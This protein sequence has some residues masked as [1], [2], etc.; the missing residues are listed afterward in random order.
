MVF[1]GIKGIAIVLLASLFLPIEV[2]A[3]PDVVYNDQ[4]YVFES[5]CQ[6]RVSRFLRT[7]IMSDPYQPE[8]LRF[9][10]KLYSNPKLA[11][12]FKGFDVTHLEMVNFE[13]KMAK[14]VFREF[15]LGECKQV[16]ES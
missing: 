16:I 13:S 10:N 2:Q 14:E 12:E 7:L 5:E 8:L 9:A 15:N 6:E 4:N 3:Q 1:K 11:D